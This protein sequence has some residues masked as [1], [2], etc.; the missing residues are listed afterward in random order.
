MAELAAAQRGLVTRAQLVAAGMRTG[1][2]DR[3]VALGRLHPVHRGVYSV[4]HRLL[5]AEGKMLA[6]ALACG[7]GVVS[8][9]HAGA[10]WGFM[11][12][13]PGPIDVTVPVRAGRESRGGIR[14]HRVP[15]AA[16]EVTRRQGIPVTSPARTLVDIAA[17][18]PR[19]R[20]ERVLD[21]A[22]YRRRLDR[23]TLACAIELNSGRAGGRVLAA[24]L[25]EHSAGSTRTRSQLEER[26]LA[27][28]STN[29]LPRPRVNCWVAG[30]EVDFLWQGARLIV[31]TD[32]LAAHGT[33]ASF[34]R[35][36]S[37]DVRLQTAGYAVMRFTHRQVALQAKG[38]MASLRRMLE[39]R[40]Q[41][42]LE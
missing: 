5:S 21:E 37:R 3:R 32:G 2:I 22:E 17:I 19:R 26:F 15:L 25:R 8:H 34:E 36:R 23:W 41:R 28:C 14:L 42:G 9:L 6:A 31:E 27:L 1:A 7:H 30:L 29:E 11:A 38:V 20:M 39:E 35:D 4:G 33:R 12:Q 40:S 13:V 18:V 24:I 10:L 16:D